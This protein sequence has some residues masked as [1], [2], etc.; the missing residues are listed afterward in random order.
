MSKDNDVRPG[1][2]S[3]DGSSQQAVSPVPA[4]IPDAEYDAADLTGFKW[5]IM[6]YAPG[7]YTGKCYG[8]GKRFYN[9]DKRAGSCL[10]CAI[11]IALA[12]SLEYERALRIKLWNEGKGRGLSD[13]AAMEH[14]AEGI[15]AAHAQAIEARR[16]ETGTGSV[17]ESAVEDAPEPRQP[18]QERQS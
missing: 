8:C 3:S 6:A 1:G 13:R 12:N 10:K 7:G 5:P 15:A 16:A 4:S 14:V 9:L 17:H 11:E 2:L 18:N